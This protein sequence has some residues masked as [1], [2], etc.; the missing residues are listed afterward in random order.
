MINVTFEWCTS[1]NGDNRRH[2][3]IAV[4]IVIAVRAIALVYVLHSLMI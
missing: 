1:A 4:V 2:W 3:V